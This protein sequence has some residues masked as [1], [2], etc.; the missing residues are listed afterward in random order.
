MIIYTHL[1]SQSCTI[2]RHYLKKPIMI[3]MQHW[4]KKKINMK[5]VKS[6]FVGLL[7][8]SGL[9][10]CTNKV[11]D[12]QSEMIDVNVLLTFWQFFI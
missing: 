3:K 2:L 4:V 10:P 7:R 6:G 8:Y 9:P 11:I 1:G 5:C 12:G